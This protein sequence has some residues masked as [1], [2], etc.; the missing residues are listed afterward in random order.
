MVNI[1]NDGDSNEQITLILLDS[2]KNYL[3]ML[4]KEFHWQPTNIYRSAR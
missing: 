3:L 2:L 4:L 1:I